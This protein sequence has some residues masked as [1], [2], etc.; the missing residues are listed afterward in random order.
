[1]KPIPKNN[2][3]PLKPYEHLPQLG[4]GIEIISLIIIIITATYIYIITKKLET[5]S[6]HKGINFF[7][8]AFLF[9]SIAFSIQIIEFS[10][11]FFNI[12]LINQNIIK[13]LFL[14][15]NLIAILYLLYSLIWKK[16]NNKEWTIYPIALLTPIIIRL[17]TKRPEFLIFFQ[18]VLGTL[19]LI[20]IF[21]KYKKAKT[22]NAK[23][24]LWVYILLVIFW[25]I[26]GI[27][28]VFKK[29]LEI[30]R[31]FLPIIK[32]LIFLTILYKVHKRLKIT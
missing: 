32:V 24:I 10:Q 14:L 25:L 12:Y 26:S 20:I 7:R 21:Q 28:F 4:L 19:I 31:N 3:I 11:R 23:Q 9:F 5:L 27:G 8:K 16:I 6:K 15:F 18:V 30:D 13:E 17:F 1:M 22:N 2:F 29:I